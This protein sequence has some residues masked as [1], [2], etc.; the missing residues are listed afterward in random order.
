MWHFNTTTP[1]QRPEQLADNLKA[2][3]LALDEEERARLDSASLTPLS[4]PYW[5]Q[6]Q[7]ASDRLSAADLALL[8]PHLKR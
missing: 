1:L 4:Y 3:D 2:A 7:T 5:H 6:V 8:A